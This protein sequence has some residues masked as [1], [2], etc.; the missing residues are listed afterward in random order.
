MKAPTAQGDIY[1]TN[2]EARAAAVLEYKNKKTGNV[3]I[4]TQALSRIIVAVEEQ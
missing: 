1:G 3:R 2:F 4:T